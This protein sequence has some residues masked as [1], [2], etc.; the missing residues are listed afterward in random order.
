MILEVE[1]QG[2][3]SRHTWGLVTLARPHTRLLRLSLQDQ[4]AHLLEQ[5][6]QVSLMLA[7]MTAVAQDLN[8]LMMTAGGW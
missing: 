4:G 2:N 7:D 3:S 6:L 5:A 1:S 8:F